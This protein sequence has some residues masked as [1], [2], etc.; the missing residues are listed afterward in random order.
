[1]VVVLEVEMAPPAELQGVTVQEAGGA[2][3]GGEVGG[4][5]EVAVA[6]GDEVVG[7]TGVDGGGEGVEVEEV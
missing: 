1:M 6:Q 3:E 7:V 2:G 5:E 4:G